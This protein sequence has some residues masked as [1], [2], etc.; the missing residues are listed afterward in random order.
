MHTWFM[1]VGCFATTR[2]FRRDILFEISEGGRLDFVDDLRLCYWLGFWNNLTCFFFN[3]GFFFDDH[4]RHL[5]QFGLHINIINYL[6][7]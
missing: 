2:F 3:H 1:L 5:N 6:R 7:C 4:C